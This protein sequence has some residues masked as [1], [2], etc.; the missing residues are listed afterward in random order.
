[1]CQNRK[2]VDVA[3][4]VHVISGD[5][6]KLIAVFF[7]DGLWGIANFGGTQLYTSTRC[8]ALMCQYRVAYVVGYI[9]V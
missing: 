8:D 2:R 3:S 4:T 9:A 1:M 5:K 7:F 6:G